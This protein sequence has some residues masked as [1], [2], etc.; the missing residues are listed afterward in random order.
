MQLP[1]NKW[2]TDYMNIYQ[3]QSSTIQDSHDFDTRHGKLL[4]FVLNWLSYSLLTK[5]NF[6]YSVLQKK[7][8]VVVK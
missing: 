5:G 2:T 1:S 4:L 3:R 8:S 6:L 7:Y